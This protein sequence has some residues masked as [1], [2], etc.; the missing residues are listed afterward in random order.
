MF[1]EIV[2]I[3]DAYSIGFDGHETGQCRSHSVVSRYVDKIYRGHED[4]ESRKSFSRLI[5]EEAKP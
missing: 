4:V 3:V 1:Y 5:T 2:T